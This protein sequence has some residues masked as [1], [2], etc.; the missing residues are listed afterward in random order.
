MVWI[1]GVDLLREKR[2]EIVL[3]YIFGIGFLRL[4]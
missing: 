1:V 4:K 2:V 3:I